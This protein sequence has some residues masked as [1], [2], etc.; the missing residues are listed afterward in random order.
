M[1]KQLDDKSNPYDIQQVCFEIG[2]RYSKLVT[3]V[4][5]QVIKT[6]AYKSGYN[7]YD[8]DP[9]FGVRIRDRYLSQKGIEISE[10]DIHA[11]S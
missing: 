11:P 3:D 7:L 5:M 1:E 10:I 6:Y 4:E 8:F 2:R 9:I